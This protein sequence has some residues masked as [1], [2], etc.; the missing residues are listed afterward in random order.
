MFGYIRPH[1]GE[2][3]LREYEI[4]K[5]VYCSLCRSMGKNFGIFSKL[6]LSYDGT[7]LALMA[8]GLSSECKGF[9]KGPCRVNP[10]KRCNYCK[11][12]DKS[13]KFAGAVSI[14]MAYY[15]LK[16]DINDGNIIQRLRAVA[17]LTVVVRAQRKARVCYPE[18]EEIVRR[19]IAKQACI[20]EVE[21]VSID[22]SA[23]ATSIM[24]SEVLGLL[25][26]DERDRRILCEMGYFVG[27]WVYLMDAVDD[28]EKDEKNKNFNVFVRALIEQ[29]ACS[30]QEAHKYLLAVLNQTLARLTAAY[31][32]LEFA[33]FQPIL[34]NIITKGLPE[35]Q[36]NILLKE[37]SDNY[38]SV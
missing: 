25:A 36:R 27:R 35:F 19:Q 4:Y 23:S 6:L 26:K 29:N 7:F 16:D 2:L 13:L 9:Q 21:G 32:L 28:M 24:L 5:G 20:E 34:D 31:N 38:G 10:I 33:Q 18:V 14:I 37:E 12:G 1:K 22:E 8:M 30:Q 17:V 15:K 3:K 11:E